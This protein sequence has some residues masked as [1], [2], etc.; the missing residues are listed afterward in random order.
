MAARLKVFVTSDGLNDY[1]VATTSKSKAL[2]AWGSHQ[3]LFK[4]GL[5]D[6]TDD[7]SLLKAATAQPG[8]VL[9][10]PAR[11]R[12]ALEQLKPI[13]PTKTK[14]SG[15]TK[16]QLRKLADLEGRLSAADKAAAAELA[17]LDARRAA[18]E[19][20]HARARAKLAADLAAARDLVERAQ[21]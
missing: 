6:E 3:D 16:T 9:K 18:L 17:E 11:S 10:R 7:A 8:Q 2:A 15:P 1:V 21:A 13:K 12:A 19:A 20:K 14:P 5:A 4:S